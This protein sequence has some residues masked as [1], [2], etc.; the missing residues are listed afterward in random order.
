M[1]SRIFPAVSSCGCLVAAGASLLAG[2]GGGLY[3]LVPA[4]MLSIV[5]GLLN[6]WVLLVEIQR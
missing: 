4:F 6:A 1:L 5:S 2:G 3:W